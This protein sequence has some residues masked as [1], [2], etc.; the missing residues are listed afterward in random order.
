MTSS[1]VEAEPQ[2][3]SS[4]SKARRLHWLYTVLESYFPLPVAVPLC[5]MLLGAVAYLH[6]R[7]VVHRDLK[8]DNIMVAHGL[9]DLRLIDFNV[10][11]CMDESGSLTPTG[12]HAQAAPEVLC[13]QAPSMASDVW[14]YGFCMYFMLMGVLPQNRDNQDHTWASLREGAV[15]AVPFRPREVDHLPDCCILTLKTCLDIQPCRRP[16]SDQLLEEDWLRTDNIETGTVAKA[17]AEFQAL[18]SLEG[19]RGE[20]SLPLCFSGNRCIC[21]SMC[22]TSTMDDTMDSPRSDT[23]SSASNSDCGLSCCYEGT[24]DMSEVSWSAMEPHD[25]QAHEL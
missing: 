25:T 23:L 6:R 19:F 14:S 20:R 1:V 16:L 9:Q 5:R 18:A 10:A 22:E 4:I 21:K 7:N 15:E 24:L 13:G 11:H 2:S 3:C 17:P 12:F 8:P